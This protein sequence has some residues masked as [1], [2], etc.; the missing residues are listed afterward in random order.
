MNVCSIVLFPMDSEKERTLANTETT[1]NINLSHIQNQFLSGRTWAFPAAAHHR[2]EAYTELKIP[3]NSLYITENQ[4]MIVTAAI[5]APVGWC[6][7]EPYDWVIYKKQ[8][9]VTHSS[10]GWKAHDHGAGRLTEQSLLSCKD[11]AWLGSRVLIT[12]QRPHILTPL[13]WALGIIPIWASQKEINVLAIL[14]VL[15]WNS[16]TASLQDGYI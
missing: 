15:H 3:G 9:G 2:V 6:Y 10:G 1:F 14:I 8:K 11:G 13:H 4:R 12:S 5:L 7:K 16:K